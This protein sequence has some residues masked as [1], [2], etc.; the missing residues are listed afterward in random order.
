MEKIKIE[1]RV[2][3]RPSR[4]SFDLY[5]DETTSIPP[6]G[7]ALVSTGISMALPEGTYGRIAPRSGLA[8]KYSV[9]TGAGVIN[10]DYRGIVKI[11]LVNHSDTVLAVKLGERVAQLIVE[12]ISLAPIVDVKS[13]QPTL[14]KINRR[15]PSIRTT[16][17]RRKQ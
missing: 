1:N 8:V 11:L 7:R 10:E 14:R 3:V 9:D 13:C 2:H 4:N 17:A 6:H 16:L 12:R 15:H 5:A